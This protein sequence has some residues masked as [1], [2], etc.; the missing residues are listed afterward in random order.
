MTAFS[1]TAQEMIV[2]VIFPLKSWN[3]LIILYLL[4]NIHIIFQIREKYRSNNI[5]K[6]RADLSE[7][8][9]PM[10][11]SHIYTKKSPWVSGSQGK[12]ATEIGSLHVL[13]TFLGWGP[14]DL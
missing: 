2:A 11:A 3:S 8:M 6:Y 7:R 14:A 5:L 10:K 12:K 1:S 13:K 9:T 4:E